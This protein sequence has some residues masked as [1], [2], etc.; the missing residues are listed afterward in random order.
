[1]SYFRMLS[2]SATKVK[3]FVLRN[4]TLRTTLAGE[5]QLVKRRFPTRRSP[6]LT[7]P[8]IY[9]LIGDTLAIVDVTSWPPTTVRSD[10]SLS[11]SDSTWL[12]TVR[13]STS[14]VRHGPSFQRRRFDVRH[15]LC[16]DTERNRKTSR[17]VFALL[18][19]QCFVDRRNVF[20]L[21][22]RQ[23]TTCSA[24]KRIQA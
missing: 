21:P 23:C 24:D 22:R 10:V 11:F 16:P 5:R 18:L 7:P 6:S 4:L 15:C 1:M 8:L 20:T 19:R 12:I 2:V 14:L 9:Y 17:T 13:C 3:H